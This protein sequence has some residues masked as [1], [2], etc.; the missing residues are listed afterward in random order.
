MP[1]ICFEGASAVGKTTLSKYLCEN[2]NAVAIPE[3]NLLFKR[4]PNEPKFWYFEKQVERWQLAVNALKNY[5]IAILDG[6]PFQPLWYNWAYNFDVFQSLQIVADFYREKIIGGKIA[7]PDQYF[8]LTV[9]DSELRKRKVNDG[10]RT[11]KN[12]ER[13][14]QFIKPQIAYFSFMKSINTDFIKFIENREIEKTAEKIVN[15]ILVE[16][17]NCIPSLAVFDAAKKW[18]SE[19]KAASFD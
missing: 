14:L 6:D 8:I 7:F 13:H 19:T 1:I 11:R 12:F 5:K 16:K 17:P 2:F 4:K 3:V 18:L 10:S 9:S 15:S